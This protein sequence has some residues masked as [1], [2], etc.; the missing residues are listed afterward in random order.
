MSEHSYYIEEGGIKY[1]K[2][3]EMDDVLFP[4]EKGDYVQYKWGLF[5]NPKLGDIRVIDG[6]LCRCACV[7]PGGIKVIWEPI[8]KLK[9]LKQTK[10]VPSKGPDKNK[11][12]IMGLFND[13]KLSK[14]GLHNKHDLYAAGLNDTINRQIDKLEKIIS[15]WE[16]DDES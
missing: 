4:A 13:L 7:V 16:N 10:N 6:S 1:K 12:K 9:E 8:I 14:A 15:E 5:K 3:I 11:E 2:I